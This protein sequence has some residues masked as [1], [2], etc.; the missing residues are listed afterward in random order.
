MRKKVFRGCNVLFFSMLLAVFFY[1]SH[2]GA[3]IK[4]KE[5]SEEAESLFH[6]NEIVVTGTK[7]PYHLKDVPVQTDVITAE[8]IE[9]SSVQTVSDVLRSVPGFFAVSEDIPGETS[10]RSSVRG[11][12]VNSGYGLVLINGQR[13]KG[14]G[15]GEYGYG[16]NQLPISM[17]ERIEV[18]KGPAS[19]LYGSDALVGVVNIITKS[20]LEKPVYGAV[21]SG[22]SNGTR[23]AS[24]YAGVKEGPV[25][26]YIHAAMNEADIGAYGVNSS[27]DEEYHLNRVDSNVSYDLNE[28][29]NCRLLM[30]MEDKDRSRIYKEKD[31][32]RNNWYRKYR[33]APTFNFI[34]NDT[35]EAVLSGYY[36]DWSMDSMESGDDSSDF[37]P[38]IGNMYYKDVET[39]YTRRFKNNIQ[40]TAGFEYLQEDL[41]YSFADKTIETISE[42]AQLET[43]ILNRVTIV[44]GARWDDHS[45]YG[46]HFSPKLSFMYRP[47]ED[48]VIRGSMGKGFKSPTIRQLYYKKLYQHGDYWYRSNIE[49]EPEKA[50]GYS[51]GIEQMVLGRIVLECSVFRNDIEDKVLQIDTD[52]EEEGLPIVTFE[53]I[54]KAY[55]QGVEISLKALFTKGL[56]GTLSYTFTDTEDEDS[57]N[58]ITYVPDNNVTCGLSY[59]YRPFG[60]MLSV[61]TQFVDKMYTNSSNTTETNAYSLVDAKI[62]KKW[63]GKYAVSIEGNNLLDSDYGQPDRKWLGDTYLIKFKMDI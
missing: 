26:G 43:E 6:L 23:M 15:M 33:V 37:S 21:I 28:H 47:S 41:D 1:F 55:T 46:S 49:L 50:V 39:R 32:I 18:I 25:S 27:R 5:P 14:E 58:K 9:K 40:L 17:I 62:E 45:E 10:W 60:L 53:N 31:V 12:D 59:K 20:C 4:N 48:T 56:T 2:A 57:G 51:L 52:D 38:T 30:S 8:D 36:F 19:V 11:L 24:A 22:G 29:V 42:Y 13:V 35:S 44:L 16:V 63:H 7:T 61:N 3:D 34:F 54:S